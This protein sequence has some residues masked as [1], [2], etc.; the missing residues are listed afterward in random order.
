MFMS[1][2]TLTLLLELRPYYFDGASPILS[3]IPFALSSCSAS[4]RCALARYHRAQLSPRSRGCSADG[5]GPRLLS[6]LAKAWRASSARPCWAR[7]SALRKA[8][9]EP[10]KSDLLMRAPMG[11][12]GVG[13]VADLGQAPRPRPGAPGETRAIRACPGTIPGRNLALVRPA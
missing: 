1:S 8:I 13:R 4:R 3:A 6:P 11:E 5:A 9:S 7:A 10:R 2:P 12:V